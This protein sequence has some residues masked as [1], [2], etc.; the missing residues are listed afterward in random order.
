MYV[1]SR[2]KRGFYGDQRSSKSHRN[3]QT[4]SNKFRSKYIA[5]VLD[6]ARGENYRYSTSSAMATFKRLS[7]V[8]M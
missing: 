4:V 5:T 1:E 6:Y 8:C 2:A 3:R 7:I